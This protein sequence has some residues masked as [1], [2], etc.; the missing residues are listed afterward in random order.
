MNTSIAERRGPSEAGVVAD[1]DLP[2]LIGRLAA[3]LATPLYPGADR[4]SLKRH[5]VG[6][7][8]PLAFY[9]LWLRHLGTELPTERQ[10]PAWALLAWGLALMGAGAHRPG[11]GLGRALAETGYA[12]AR[13]ERLLA[14]DNDTRERLFTSLVRFL[15][16]KGESFDWLDAGRL[17]LT[18]DSDV[19]E[20]L[21]RRI[22]TDYYRHLP[23]QDKD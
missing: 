16:A 19:R 22:A 21:N 9:R 14:A 13:L 2:V 11:H 15:A 6:Q 20:A 5:A 10:T 1:T 3:Q 7:P 12:E 4:A 8:P 23:R 18:R 17:L